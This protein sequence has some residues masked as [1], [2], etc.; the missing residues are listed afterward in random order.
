MQLINAIISKGY[1]GEVSFHFLPIERSV[2]KNFWKVVAPFYLT[3]SIGTAL[4]LAPRGQED[5][6][7]QR[8]AALV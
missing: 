2:R 3:V 7:S 5:S 8:L 1:L 4:V 6:F